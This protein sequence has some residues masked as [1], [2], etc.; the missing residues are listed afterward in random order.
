MYLILLTSKTASDALVGGLEA[1]ADEFVSKPFDP[2]ALRAR[3]QVGFRIPELQQTL[4][5]RVEELEAALSRVRQLQ[6]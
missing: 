2:A 4:A 3:T 1:G 5:T 6:G